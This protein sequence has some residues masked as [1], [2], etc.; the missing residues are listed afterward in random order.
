[1]AHWGGGIRAK[2]KQTYC[3]HLQ[4]KPEYVA[5]KMEALSSST[6]SDHLSTT[7]HGKPKEYHYLTWKKFFFKQNWECKVLTTICHYCII[8]NYT[9][10]F[11]EGLYLHN[12]IFL[13]L[14][15]DTSAI[16]L[17][18]TLGWGMYCHVLLRI[19][20]CHVLPRT[21]TIVTYCYVLS[22][23]AT[24]SYVL[25]CMVAYCHVWSRIVTYCYLFSRTVTY[26]HV[27]SLM[28]AYCHVWSRI[29][30]YC[31]VLLRNVKHQNWN[32]V[33]LNLV[34]YGY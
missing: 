31:H 23:T 30:T 15:S 34:I 32:M 11:I 4:S 12:L 10:I 7:G 1:M 8:A 27:L 2:N 33:L 28:V 25:S 18:V 24:Y 16:T 14:F 3:L 21:V 29:V 19:V 9:W 13:A 6:T 17:Y 22:R 20:Y 26:S 5:L